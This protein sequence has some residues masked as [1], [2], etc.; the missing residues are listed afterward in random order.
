[1]LLG[2]V[3]KDPPPVITINNSPVERVQSF[4]LLGV[5]LTSSLSS[6]SEHITAVCTKASKRLYFLKLL[7]RSGMTSD[8][9]LYYYK[10]VIRPVTE[11][12]FAVWHSSIT[13]E[14]RD[15]LEAIQRRAVRI[16]FGKKMDFDI[17]AIIHEFHYLQTDAIDKWELFTGMHDSSHCLHRLLQENSV[18]SAIHTLRNR[19]N[20]RCAQEQTDLKTH[21]YYIIYMP[22]ETLNECSWIAYL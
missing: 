7:K 8:D 13:A 17:F 14:Q 16:I 2:S 18:A 3:S 6:W 21:L 1:M 11:Y 9:L 20:Y 10:T 5:L 4:K 15:Q 22:C 19:K 12:T